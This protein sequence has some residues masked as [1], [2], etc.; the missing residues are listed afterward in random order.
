MKKFT[1]IVKFI[2][3]EIYYK[4]IL[5]NIRLFE[6]GCESLLEFVYN[7]YGSLE[8]LKEKKAVLLTFNSCIHKEIEELFDIWQ[9]R[10]LWKEPYVDCYTLIIQDWTDP[11]ELTMF[12]KMNSINTI[13][14]YE[15]VFLEM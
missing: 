8:Y 13:S 2:S 11:R 1:V 6:K 5:H 15:D 10:K 12:E 7:R 9:Q 14:P 4:Y 3:N